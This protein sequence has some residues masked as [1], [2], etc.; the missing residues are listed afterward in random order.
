MRQL[1]TYHSLLNTLSQGAAA[2]M[3]KIMCKTLTLPEVAFRG[4]THI[5]FSI[6]TLR[7]FGLSQLLLCRVSPRRVRELAHDAHVGPPWQA[8][9]RLAVSS[10]QSRVDVVGDPLRVIGL[11]VRLCHACRCKQTGQ[12]HAGQ[13]DFEKSSARQSDG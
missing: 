5:D 4:T 3:C 12:G 6:A 2:F 8:N 10:K 1:M 9:H 7:L 11:R 13:I